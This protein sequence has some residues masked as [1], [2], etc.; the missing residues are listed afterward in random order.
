MVD[1]RGAEPGVRAALRDVA[2]ALAVVVLLPAAS[3]VGIF[4]AWLLGA[5]LGRALEWLGGR[6]QNGRSSPAS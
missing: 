5:E 1:G 6:A 3:M 2:V 4:F